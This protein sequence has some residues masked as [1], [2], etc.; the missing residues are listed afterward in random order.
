MSVS[1]IVVVMNMT[2]HVFDTQRGAL[3]AT[4]GIVTSYPGGDTAVRELQPL[5][6]G[7]R[8]SLIHI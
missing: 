4:P 3:A 7:L 6:A 8:L 2:F 5:G 1:T